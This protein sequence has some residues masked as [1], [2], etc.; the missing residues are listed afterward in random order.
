MGTI[1]VAYGGGE[2]RTTVLEFAAEQAAVSEHDLFVYHAQASE[3]DAVQQ[4]HDEIAAVIQ[5]TAPDSPVE[6]E[7]ETR[8]EV[9]D[10]TNVSDQK[11]LTDA[12]R[13]FDRDCEYIV[14]GDSERDSLEG[15][16]HGSMTEAVLKMRAAPVVVVPV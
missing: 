10:Q 12:I 2:H 11:R 13:E 5:R 6:V 8:D 16:S 14:V 15:L 4:L 1:F 9:S 3:A 7:I